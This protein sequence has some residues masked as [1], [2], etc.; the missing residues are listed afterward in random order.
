MWINDAKE[1]FNGICD[2]IQHKKFSV[3][4][5]LSKDFATPRIASTSQEGQ[6]NK[7]LKVTLLSSEWR[8]STDGDLST[9]SRKLAIQL[10]KF[11]NVEV[12]VFLPQCSNEDRRN[13]AS[14]N[15]QLIEAEQMV[16]VNPIDWLI[17]VPDGHVMDCVL[18]HGVTLGKQ[19]QFIKKAH[20]NCKW[21][22]V[23]HTAPEEL[24]IYKNILEGEK[25]QKAEVK[26]CQLADEVVA[27]GPKLAD[28][29]KRYLRSVK[30]EQSVFDITPGIF[31]EFLDIEQAVEERRTFCVLV[32]GGGDSC[33]DFNLQGSNLTFEVNSRMAS[34]WSGFT[35]QK[36]IS[37][38]QVYS[39]ILSFL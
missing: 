12:S 10:A 6:Q 18:G 29:Y 31:S 17:N 35:S 19:V 7:T 36:C 15:V 23:V 32:I 34:T 30:K 13:A 27:I 2:T 37:T 11:S 16:G 3:M 4:S 39:T 28:A 9:I 8:S 38:R 33:E 1:P 14:H 21:I 25:Q 24:G 20:H 26:L 5:G 22:Q